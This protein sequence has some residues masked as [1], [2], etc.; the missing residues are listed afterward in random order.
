MPSLLRWRRVSRRGRGLLCLSVVVVSTLATGCGSEAV[1]APLPRPPAQVVVEMGEYWYE[2]DPDIPAG[3]VVFRFANVGTVDH[4]LGL[5]PLEEDFPPIDV[6]LHG[7]ERRFLTPFARS[8]IVRP[9]ATGTFAVDLL[10]GQRYA[11]ICFLRGP[12]GEE[13]EQLGMNSEFRAG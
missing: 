11:M 7:Q 3:R 10:P 5:W 1:S 4:E 2:Y 12:Q 13:H 8:E 9:G 6:Q